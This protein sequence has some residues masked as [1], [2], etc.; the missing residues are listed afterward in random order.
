MK[1]RTKKLSARYY[2]QN[3]LT[4]YIA[5]TLFTSLPFMGFLLGFLLN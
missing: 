5:L 4:R 2:R 3:K 1:K